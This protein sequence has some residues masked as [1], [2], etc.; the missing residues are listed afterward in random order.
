MKLYRE[1]QFGPIVP[2]M[3]YSTLD[4]ALAYVSDSSFGQQVSLFGQDAG[5]MAYLIDRLIRQVGRINLNT[6]C[7]R[8]P[9]SFPFT[10]GRTRR[11]ERSPY[12]M[13]CSHFL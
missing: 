8:G 6:Q 10:A 11:K 7:Q 4:E 1:E 3:T 2:V 12:G 13:L 9:D 5:A